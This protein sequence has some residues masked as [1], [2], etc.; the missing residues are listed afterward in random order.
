MPESGVLGSW[1]C[2]YA[3]DAEPSAQN[4]SKK[5]VRI[6][7]LE[8]KPDHDY[9]LT[10][11]DGEERGQWSYT[12][13]TLTLIPMTRDRSDPSYRFFLDRQQ[14]RISEVP[15]NGAHFTYVRG[16]HGLSFDKGK[17]P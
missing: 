13:G 17:T 10:G 7:S 5:L 2:K 16:G 9:Q 3:V 15:G 8:L 4:G 14:C 1:T 12:P 11:G 6:L